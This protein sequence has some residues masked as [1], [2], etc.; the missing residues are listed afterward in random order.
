MAAVEVPPL[1]EILA[2]ISDTRQRQGLRHSLTGMLTL[3]CVATMCGYESPSAIAEWGH[4]YGEAYAGMF[5][6]ETHG[7]P[8]R[9]TWY[10]VFGQVDIEQVEAKL[11]QWCEWVL[12]ALGITEVQLTGLSID[13]KTLRGSKRQGAHNSHLL[14]AYVHEIGIVLAQIAV[15]DKTNELGEVEDFLLGLALHGRVVTADA[16]FTQQKVAETI[17]KKEGDYVF[18]V[19]RNQELTFDAIAFWFD[20]LAPYDLPND[21]AQTIEKGHGRVT[22][23][24]LESSTALNTYLDW[25]GLKQVFKVTRTVTWPGSGD[26]QTSVRY[27]ITSLSPERANAA[28]LLTFT[29]NHWGIENGLHWVRDVTFHEDHS[30]LRTGRT[31]HLMAAIRNLAISLLRI[32]GYTRIASTLRLFAA[33]PDLALSLTLEPLRLGE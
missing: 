23:W 2:E 14:S 32:H 30:I 9:A 22:R 16:L 24:S 8:S 19:K 5:G 11:T 21:V 17:I 13:G 3:A 31:H 4:N 26:M 18:P 28:H 33:Q 6:F 1:I 20:A 29:R 27:G 10:R 15:D 12:R 25:P 7:Y